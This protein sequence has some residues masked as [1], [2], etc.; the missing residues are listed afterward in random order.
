MTS[1]QDATVRPATAV[2]LAQ[3]RCAKMRGKTVSFLSGFERR[4]LDLWLETS[5]C[6]WY[7]SCV[8]SSD[9]MHFCISLT[10]VLDELTQSLHWHMRHMGHMTH[11]LSSAGT[12]LAAYSRD[13]IQQGA[14]FSW[15][16]CADMES[17]ICEASC[18]QDLCIT[19]KEGWWRHF[20]IAPF[21]GAQLLKN[22]T[23]RLVS[24][25][26][27]SLFLVSK[28]VFRLPRAKPIPKEKPKTR[29]QKFMEELWYFSVSF[30]CRSLI[31][32][33]SGEEHEKEEKKSSCLG[34]G[35]DGKKCFQKSLCSSISST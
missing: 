22:G 33:I 13:S 34:W 12:D 27:F 19:K 25:L 1:T 6:I 17:Q 4:Q 29:F 35:S 26:Q 14:E 28:G 15:V 7:L 31:N 18:E 24:V 20:G 9:G 23:S 10:S 16:W 5:G 21:R 3:F 30:F 11:R 32:R 8:M 2:T